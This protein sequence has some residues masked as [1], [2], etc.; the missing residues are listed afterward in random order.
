MTLSIHNTTD[1]NMERIAAYGPQ[2]TAAFR[3]LVERFP[4]DMTLKSLADDVMSGRQQL[5]L[6]MDGEEFKSFLTTEIKTND[7][8]GHKT[9]N[10]I[11]LAGEGGQDL[12]YLIKDVE[13]WA[14]EQGADEIIPVCR[15]GFK[16]P[17]ES[18]GYRMDVSLFRKSLKVERAS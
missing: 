11:N 3:K 17:L 18:L 7:Y 5:W 12:T 1:W 9:V 6:I 8:T 14:A 16:K 15:S 13:D 2:I 10:L 4:N